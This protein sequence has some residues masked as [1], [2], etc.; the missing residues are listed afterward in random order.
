[1]KT[2]STKAYLI[3]PIGFLVAA[4]FSIRGG[5]RKYRPLRHTTGPF[6]FSSRH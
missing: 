4:A 5:N 6:K 3:G 1:M 2:A